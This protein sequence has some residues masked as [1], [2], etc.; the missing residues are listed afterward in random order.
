MAE[1]NT[2]KIVGITL[3]SAVV[4]GGVLYLILRQSTQQKAVEQANALS[5]ADKIL[6][7]AIMKQNPNVNPQK[8]M[9]DLLKK[10]QQQKQGGAKSGGGGTGGSGGG[11][12]TKGGG[13]KGGG[14][15]GTGSGGG[16]YGGYNT[17]D[18][19]DFLDILSQQGE[20]TYGIGYS[21]GGGDYSGGGV[22]GGGGDY[23]GGGDY[24]VFTG[25]GDYG[26]GGSYGDG[27]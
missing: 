6:L 3:A 26:G 21:G 17:G 18:D 1:N 22:Y 14:T 7:A 11:G 12:G 10:L 9:S 20:Y 13:T 15:G 4:V 19:G 8:N 5:E 16:I 25:G 27:Y 23:S 24:N 2:G